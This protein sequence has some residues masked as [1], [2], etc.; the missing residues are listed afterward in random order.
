MRV[1]IDGP[2]TRQA[3]WITVVLGMASYLDAA[4]IA[5]TG[6]ALV[7]YQKA[8]GLTG[9]DIGRLSA[10]LTLSIAIGALVGG[11]LGD[12]FGRRR[13]FAVTMVLLAAGA[14]LLTLAISPAFIYVGL[15]LLGLSSGADLP[16]SLS[17]IGEA[18][19]DDKRGAMIGFT[20]F[21]WIFGIVGVI[22]IGIFFGSLGATGARIIYGHILVI[23]IVVLIL[24]AGIPESAKWRRA[25]ETRTD[26]IGAVDAVDIGA[27]RRLFGSRFVL[28]VIGLGLFFAIANISANTN[29]QFQTYVYV[30]VAGL[31]VP[32]ASLFGLI[33]IAV[34]LASVLVFM[35]LVDKVRARRVMLWVAA[36]MALAAFLVPATLGVGAATIIASTILFSLG[37]GIMGEPMYKV[38]SQEIIPVLF[39][40]SVQ[41]I[42]IA[43]TRLVAA[44]VALFTPAIIATGATN[45]YWFL[46]GT[47]LVA[48]L[49]GL[50]WLPRFSRADDAAGIDRTGSVAA[51][52]SDS[53]L[54][55]PSTA[56][57]R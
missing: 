27:L 30:N 39:R 49:L 43:F 46:T 6:T 8:L 38:W 35:R 44:G 40:S 2:T 45:L 42:T 54:A 22:L 53:A 33:S 51:I 18:A 20:N 7:L 4:S 12:R 24:R 5:G 23:A 50:F 36:V 34:G 13:V 21:L 11:R 32:T 31:D 47:T 26:A 10:M 56:T 3:W 16:V 41:G 29:G 55:A 1:G 15:V 57:S 52:E 19:P 17:M 28:P 9:D 14:L 37:G 48:V 25:E